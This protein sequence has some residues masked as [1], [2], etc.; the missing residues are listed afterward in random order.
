MS[1]A[2]QDAIVVGTTTVANGGG[3][4]AGQDQLRGVQLWLDEVNARG[5]LLGRSLT[6]KYYDDRGDFETTAAMYHKLITDDKANLLIGPPGAEVTLAAAATAER[7]DVPMITLGAVP[8]E[9]WRRGYKNIFGLY[10]PV[11][12]HA[13]PILELAKTHGLRRVAIVWQNTPVMREL[14]A[15]IKAHSN[16][17]GLQIV[18]DDAYNQDAVD[19]GALINQLKAKRPDV[20]IVASHLT[21][22]LGWV[23]QLKENQVSAKLMALASAA[24]PEFGK[25]LG[26][27]A[28]GVM[29]ISQWE[30]LSKIPAANEFARRFKTKYGYEPG[31]AAAGGYAAGQV[32]EATVK[33]SGSLEPA[34][35][36]RAASDLDM[37]TAFG[38]YK[39]G[40]TGKQLGKSIYIVQWI[41]GERS[42]VLPQD[43]ATAAPHYPFRQWGKR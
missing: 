40:A 32:L 36:R 18:M 17:L 27:D 38:R 1:A 2:E 41:N 8:D 31:Y 43:A 26:A 13:N 10:A 24:L 14:A 5:G 30:P 19:F 15:G 6:L 3:A 39:V 20:L 16:A 7:G 12:I 42:V 9:L 25:S 23:R 37:Q 33:K 4:R 22:S 35:L 21:D 28:D 29:G 11:D 34:R